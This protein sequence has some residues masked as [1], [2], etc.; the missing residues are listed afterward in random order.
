MS[1][2]RSSRTSI[3]ELDQSMF[4]D[5]NLKLTNAL[6]D[7]CLAAIRSGVESLPLL[8]ERE[9]VF[10]RISKPYLKNLDVIEA[11]AGRRIFTVKYAGGPRRRQEIV[12]RF[13]GNDDT[14]PLDLTT[15]VTKD[16]AKTTISYPSKEEI[17]TEEDMKS[18]QEDLKVL[19]AKLKEAKLRRDALWKQCADLQTAHQLTSSA[20]ET[21]QT[22][23]IASLHE[24]I[25]AAVMGGQGL[26]DMIRDARTLQEDLDERKR[27]VEDRGGDSMTLS[28]LPSTKKRVLT[29]EELYQHERQ[30]VKV[31]KAGLAAFLASSKENV[32]N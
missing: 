10:S 17:P 20:A 3:E 24:P 23:N 30:A 2:E 16:E 4:G 6:T 29:S 26:Q 21:I 9:D 15:S 8:Q 18:V 12:N 32:F 19:S 22:A 11:Y 5:V 31:S 27:A 13:L 14:P 28:E 25:S 1:S 7:S